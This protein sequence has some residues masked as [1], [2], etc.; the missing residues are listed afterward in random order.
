M[1]IRDRAKPGM[2][3]GRSG[4]GIDELKA[5]LEKMTNKTILIDIKEVRRAEGD[6]QLT[7]CLLYTSRC[8]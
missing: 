3:I 5:E 7:A 1:C 2:V 8:V 6:A 4:T